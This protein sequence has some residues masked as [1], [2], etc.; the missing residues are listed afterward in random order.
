MIELHRDGDVYV[1]HMRDEENRMNRT[2]LDAMNAALDEVEADPTA[3]ALVT[4]GEVRLLEQEVAGL[5]HRRLQLNM[6]RL[7]VPPSHEEYLAGRAELDSL[8]KQAEDVSGQLRRLQQQRK[9]LDAAL[10][11]VG[12]WKR[13]KQLQFMQMA[14][15][16]R[17]H[18]LERWQLIQAWTFVRW[19]ERDQMEEW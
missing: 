8:Q 9:P 12:V 15:L 1:L 3:G 14:M 2:W 18:W 6:R 17:L 16:R 7:T 4:T 5:V 10:R 13:Q 11:L 19:P